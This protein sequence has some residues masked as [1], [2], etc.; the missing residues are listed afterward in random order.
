[1]VPR[2]PFA[3]RLP[4]RTGGGRNWLRRAW[5]LLSGVPGGKLVFSRLLG[6]TAPYTASIHA[7]V[8]VLRAGYAEVEMADR[9]SVR[10]HLDCIHAVA[11][12]NLGELAANVALGYVLPDDA[13][14]IVSGLEIEY[15]KKARGT[16]TA[17]GE[18]PIPRTAVRATYEVPVTLR[19]TE[20]DEVAKVIVHVLV[21]PKPGSPDGRGD[22]N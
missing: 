18:P 1:M 21:G 2:M 12:A 8:T 16:I 19:D 7:S 11:L 4:R 17:I 5:D 14:F 13:R 9:R 20:G 6:R 15:A 22:V 3:D 10:N